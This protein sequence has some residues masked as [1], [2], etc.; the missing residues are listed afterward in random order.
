MRFRLNCIKCHKKI[1]M[2]I[3]KRNLCLMCSI[4]FYDLIQILNKLK[5]KGVGK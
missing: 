5:L 1:T 2:E 4:K 3:S